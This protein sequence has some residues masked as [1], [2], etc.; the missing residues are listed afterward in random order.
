M[1]Q[2]HLLRLDA[3]GSLRRQMRFHGHLATTAAGPSGACAIF[4][5][6]YPRGMEAAHYHLAVFDASFKREWTRDSPPRLRDHT[7]WSGI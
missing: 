2:L 7:E 6:D 4:Y 3:A 1:Q 5:Y